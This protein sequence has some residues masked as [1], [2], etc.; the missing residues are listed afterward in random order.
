MIFVDCSVDVWSKKHKIS[1]VESRCP[2]CGALTRTTIPVLTKDGYGLIA[3]EHKC[4]KPKRAYTFVPKCS[5][6]SSKLG[7]ILASF[8][9]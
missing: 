3:P 6:V 8:S 9:S 4:S 7:T 1:P 2:N 5:E